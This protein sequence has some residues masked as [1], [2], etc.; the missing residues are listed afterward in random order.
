MLF[1][2]IE[3]CVSFFFFSIQCKS[4]VSKSVSL[5]TSFKIYIYISVFHRSKKSCKFIVTFSTRNTVMH[6][7]HL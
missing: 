2:V 3:E 4:V 5:P 1:Y 6:T 7:F